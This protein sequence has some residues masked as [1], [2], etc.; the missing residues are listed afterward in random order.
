MSKLGTTAHRSIF[1]FMTTEMNTVLFDLRWLLVLV[2]VLIIV[3]MWFGTSESRMH[4]E[5]AKKINDKAGME[6]YKFHL[7]RCGRRTFNKSIDYIAY[8]LVGAVL[9]LS[10]LGQY[11]I[12]YVVSA[13]VAIGFG[14]IFELSSIG[15]HI[16][17][18][19]HIIVP[20]ITMKTVLKFI[21]RTA[22]G[23]AKTKDSDLGE[24][25]DESL[26]KTLNEEDK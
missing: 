26:T 14:G 18:L 15:G 21:A 17:A 20:K 1:V 16:L 13:G 22:I 10:I 2:G 23:F 19:H 12:S 24:A 7:S 4:Y 6:K 9:G 3:D 11:G 8:L 5:E 25:L